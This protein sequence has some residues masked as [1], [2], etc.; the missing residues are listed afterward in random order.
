MV[1]QVEFHPHLVQRD[2]LDFC[3]QNSI[4][5]EAWSPLMQGK[6]LEVPL[7]QQLSVKYQRTIPQIVLRW[8][9]AMGVV[10][11]P[12]SA[13]KQRIKDNLDIFGFELEKADIDKITKL[14]KNKRLGADPDNFDF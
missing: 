8:N 6:A 12:K 1:N 9:I 13:H 7:L 5:Y 10:T 2:L 4:Q 14:D 11:I 3:K